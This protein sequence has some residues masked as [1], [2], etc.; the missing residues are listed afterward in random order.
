MEMSILTKESILFM[1]IHNS[2]RSQMAEGFFRNFYGEDYEV[3]SA[4]SDPGEI[5][6]TAIQVMDEIGIDISKHT[7]NSLKD[8]ECQEFDY[9]VT[10]CGNPYNAC[11]FFVGGKKYFKKPFED[12]SIFEGSETE[13]IEYFRGIRDEIGDWIQDL[14]NY[15]I[16]VKGNGEGN[17]C[18]DLDDEDICCDSDDDNCCEPQDKRTEDNGCCTTDNVSKLR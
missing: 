15:Q 8:Y 14:F 5:N 16:N 4:G 3:F 7:T 1:C 10:V 12:P 2:S 9:V 18:C 11:P 13:K 17:I 6:Q